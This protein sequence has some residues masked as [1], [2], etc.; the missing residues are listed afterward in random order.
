L[1]VLVDAENVPANLWLRITDVLTL[2]VPG[3]DWRV[4]AF[5]CGDDGGWSQHANVSLVD[6]GFEFRAKNSADFLL[7]FHAGELASHGATKEVAIVSGDDG[8]ALVAKRLREAGITVY[9]VIPCGSG[10]Y[11]CRLADAASLALLAPIPAE[12]RGR[13]ATVV[14][15]AAVEASLSRFS[16]RTLEQARLGREIALAMSR[17][18]RDADG[19]TQMADLGVE[20]SRSNIAIGN[21][22]LSEILTSLECFEFGTSGQGQGVRLKTPKTAELTSAAETA[23]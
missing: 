19:W 17:C 5:F 3:R 4:Q 18:R 14:A 15:D 23:S 9:A 7:A 11:G 22:K 1:T 2:A 12:P 6:G 10:T 21:K 20:V 8:L 16:F 13:S